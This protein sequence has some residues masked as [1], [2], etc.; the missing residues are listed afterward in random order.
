MN[1]I[2]RE[3][4]RMPPDQRPLVTALTTAR[5]VT[6]ERLDTPRRAWVV[7]DPP[8][9]VGDQTTRISY[10]VSRSVFAQAA[11]AVET[12]KPSEVGQRTFR[13]WMRREVDRNYDG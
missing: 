13:Y 8:P 9:R 4:Q 10:T 11:D 1:R 5:P 3:V 6:V 2:K 7:P 12:D